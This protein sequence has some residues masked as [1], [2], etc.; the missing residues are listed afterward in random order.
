MLIFLNGRRKNIFVYLG[1]TIEMHF[2]GYT[3]EFVLLYFYIQL[4][5]NF[6]FTYIIYI[7]TYIFC[8][9]IYSLKGK[10]PLLSEIN[11]EIQVQTTNLLIIILITFFSY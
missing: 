7:Y 5:N 10:T 1:V 6:A 9:L 11:E 3:Q 2:E 4:L 8:L